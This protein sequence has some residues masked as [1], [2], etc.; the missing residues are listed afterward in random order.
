MEPV[1][2]GEGFL[3]IG[4]TILGVVGLF[5]RKLDFTYVPSQAPYFYTFNRVTWIPG[6]PDPA[7]GNAV[8]SQQ[9]SPVRWYRVG[10]KN[11][12]LTTLTMSE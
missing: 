4:R 12:T 1:S 3:A 6:K 11:R 9:D 7:T 2:I 10:I 8:G 5:V